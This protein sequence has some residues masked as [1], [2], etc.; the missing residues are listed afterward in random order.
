MKVNNAMERGQNIEHI[1]VGAFI[2]KQVKSRCIYYIKVGA[3]KYAP[4]VGAKVGAFVL[5]NTL[6]SILQDWGQQLVHTWK[7]TV[8]Y[9]PV[10]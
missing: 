9:S 6:Y 2:K 1:K 10:H 7:M 3:R 8:G 4:K 5:H